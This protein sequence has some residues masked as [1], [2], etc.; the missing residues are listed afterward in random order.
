MLQWSTFSAT[1]IGDD[2]GVLPLRFYKPDTIPLGQLSEL[3]RRGWSL[4]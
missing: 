3:I 1:R 2:I 4:I